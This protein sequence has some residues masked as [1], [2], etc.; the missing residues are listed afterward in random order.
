MLAGLVLSAFGLLTGCEALGPETRS[1]TD[2]DRLGAIE[3]KLGSLVLDQVNCIDGD[4]TDWK[5]FTV[6][7]ESR[8]AVSFAFDEPSAGGTVVIR[9]P[10]G[11]E[12]STNKFV[13]GARMTKVFDAVPGYYYLEIYCEAFMSEYTIEVTKQ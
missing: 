10:T 4:K 5:Y 9:K 13:P 8:I 1:G 3:M 6:D 11:E 12:L 2:K 7:E